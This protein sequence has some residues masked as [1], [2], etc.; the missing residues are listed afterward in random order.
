ME[1]FTTGKATKSGTSGNDVGTCSD[2]VLGQIAGL[3]QSRSR[4][5]FSDPDRL[6]TAS[7]DGKVSVFSQL[8]APTA[9][10]A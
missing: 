3:A 9:I 10:T 6:L 7:G 1:W 4:L 5:W 2:W 8:A